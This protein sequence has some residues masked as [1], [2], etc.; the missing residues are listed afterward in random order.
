M[1]ILRIAQLMYEEPKRTARQNNVFDHW[2]GGGGAGDT[3]FSQH[4]IQASCFDVKC[5]HFMVM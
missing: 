4:Q 1:K 2:G 3:A 5:N